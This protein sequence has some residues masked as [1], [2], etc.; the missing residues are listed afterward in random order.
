MARTSTGGTTETNET[1]IALRG[2]GRRITKISDRGARL[3]HR[4]TTVPS[5][6]RHSATGSRAP[7][8]RHRT[9]AVAL[10]RGAGR[11]RGGLR[12]CPIAVRCRGAT[13]TASWTH[14]QATH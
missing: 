13:A 4:R 10:R 6:R 8:H 3:T 1:T 2:G 11:W 14:I 5:A 12:R 7:C 9:A